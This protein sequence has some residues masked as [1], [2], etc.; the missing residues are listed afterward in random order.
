VTAAR[1]LLLIAA[2]VVCACS[3]RA[4][5]STPG[6]AGDRVD[7][8]GASQAPSAVIDSGLPVESR[9]SLSDGAIAAL[10]A[11]GLLERLD[12]VSGIAP[13]DHAADAVKYANIWG[14]PPYLT[15]DAAWLITTTGDIFLR[16]AKGHDPTCLVVDGE[17]WWVMTGGTV[18]EDGVLI[19]PLVDTNPPLHVPPLA[20]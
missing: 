7:R 6:T 10:S 19:P 1:P 17:P 12:L 14:S 5:A 15:D 4:P 18:G 3:A 2:L 20:P 11:C 13:L 9:S 16:T 8:F